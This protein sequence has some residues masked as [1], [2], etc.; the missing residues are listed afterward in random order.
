MTF[1]R[2]LRNFDWLMLLAVVGLIVYGIFLIFSAT[3]NHFEEGGPRSL[4]DF[5]DSL[6]FRQFIFAFIG[7]LI[8]FGAAAFDYRWLNRLSPW[9]YGAV[10]VLLAIVFFLGEINFG[11]RRWISAGP[12]DIQPSELAKLAFILFLARFLSE[13]EQRLSSIRIF[14]LSLGVL[15]LPVVLIF[16]QPDLGTVAMFVTAWL[17]MLIV[18]GARLLHIG[19]VVASSALAAPGAYLFLLH[20]YMRQRVD[21]FLNPTADPSG[22]G[23]N[24]IQA[25]IAI[26]S[27]GLFGKGY[28]NGTQTQLNYLR[29]RFTDFIFSVLGEELG[30]IGAILLFALFLIVLLRGLR[31][32]AMASDT[33]GRLVAVGI[34][35]MIATQMFINIGVNVRL[36]PVTGVPLPFV[37]YGG[38]SLLTNLLAIGILQSIALRRRTE[39]KWSA[40]HGLEV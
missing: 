34:V 26:G 23:Y 10:V 4:H 2:R 20:D 38:S 14:L 9:I 21:T 13:R 40:A 1:W 36:L 7:L 6:V 24:V 27:G 11:S 22:A 28:L 37:S 15:V 32:S 35:M 33:F 3:T 18:A 16:L 30:F 17:G 8:L 29:V 12:I 19:G 25:E 31:I 39:R 5:V